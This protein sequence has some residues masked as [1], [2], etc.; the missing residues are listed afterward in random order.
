MIEREVRGE[1]ELH[2][3]VYYNTFYSV[4]KNLYKCNNP[5]QTSSV[6][7]HMLKLSPSFRFQ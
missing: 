6:G 7:R 3:Y 2:E 4:G 5:A 1:E